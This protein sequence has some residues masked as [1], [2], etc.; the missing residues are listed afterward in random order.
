M[1]TWMILLGMLSVG[2]LT[3]AHAED[4]DVDHLFLEGSSIQGNLDKPHVVYIVP[5][6][7]IPS[8]AG[9]PLLF[10]RSFLNDILVPVDRDR[11]NQLMQNQAA[12][13]TKRGDSENPSEK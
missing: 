6:K 1:R 11:F 5:W 12:D 9:D 7:D 2:M 8:N 4:S 13:R 3:A 10:Q